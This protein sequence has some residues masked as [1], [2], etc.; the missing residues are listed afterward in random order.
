MI[1]TRLRVTHLLLGLKLA[2]GVAIV[3]GAGAQLPG[4]YAQAT[5]IPSIFDTPVGEATGLLAAT[6]TATMTVTLK[7]PDAD[8]TL[9]ATRVP[10]IFD[11]PAAAPE[12]QPAS[13]PQATRVPSNL[14]TLTPTGP[15]ESGVTPQAT[16]I[17]SIFDAP[18]EP[19]AGQQ[20]ATRVPSI[21]DAPA[22]T[23]PGAPPQPAPY[24]SIF[25]APAGD[26]ISY[27]GEG[28]PD[29][30]YCLGCHANP[31]V[32]LVL[33]SGEAISV[34]VDETEYMESVHGQ[35]GTKGYRCIRCHTGMNQYPH[36]EV[37]ATTARELV[38]DYSTSCTRCH[39]DKYDETLD[40]VHFSLLASGNSDAAVCGDCHTGHA[41]ARL[42]DRVTGAP[43][44]DSSQTSVE[45]CTNC[46]SE[47]YETFAASVHGSALLEGNPDVPT[48]TD[49]HGVHD[50]EGPS[51]ASFRLF[52]PQTCAECHADET[53]MAEYDIS[54][55]VFDTYVADFHGTTVTIFQNTAP[56]QA[57]NSPVCVDC[58]GVHDIM[59][60][61]SENSRVLKDNLMGTCQ[62]CHPDAQADFPDAWLSHYEPSFDRTPLVALADT[63]YS[64]LIP[65]VVGGLGMFVVTDV[66]RR[67]AN[68]RKD[69]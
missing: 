67:R 2:C 64:L 34:T 46:H 66:Y 60:V 40:G 13:P 58:H 49:C 8:V 29:T 55:N 20:Q 50:T 47:I 51:A 24:T 52:S 17:P 38:I 69:R 18:T 10:S 5:R 4:L 36:E 48:C 16:R 37:S 11:T 27:K 22:E 62:R 14:D 3:I 53:L 43:L 7:A 1:F 28:P 39:P 61:D 6:P 30:Q 25:D 65:T 54:T 42:T 9:Q 57:V 68:R 21:F 26:V 33:P 44:P 15:A 59:A 23:T 32:Q 45:M 35:H 19:P 56:D 63:I 12:G 31:Y 41:V